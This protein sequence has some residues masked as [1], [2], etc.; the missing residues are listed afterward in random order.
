MEDASRGMKNRR[1]LEKGRFV[2]DY[3]GKRSR[4][5]SLPA[6][7]R[8]NFVG[9]DSTR[10]RKRCFIYLSNLCRLSFFVGR[11]F[12]WKMNGMLCNSLSNFSCNN[13]F[14]S[15]FQGNQTFEKRFAVSRKIVSLYTSLF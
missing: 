11:N 10:G 2:G 9:Y 12:C 15:L 1:S 14:P 13:S 8:I 7:S 6:S 5:H 4:S 3:F